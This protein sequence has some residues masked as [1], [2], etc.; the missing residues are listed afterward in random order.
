MPTVTGTRIKNCNKTGSHHDQLRD[1]RLERH[2]PCARLYDALLAPF[3]GK[4]LME[5]GPRGCL[6]ATGPGAPMLGIMMPHDG[7]PARPG[8]GTM[9]AIAADDRQQVDAMHANAMLLGA[10]DAGAPGPRG[11]ENSP[12]Y[13]AYFRDLDG[14]KLAVFHWRRD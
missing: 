3:G 2:P 5:L 12:F 9:V 8:N 10:T 14:N 6:Y 1:D 13:G 7:A 11:G 4:R